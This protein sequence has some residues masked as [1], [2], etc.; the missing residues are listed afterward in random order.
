META[1]MEQP[2]KKAR[3]QAQ[4]AAFERCLAAREKAILAKHAN[5]P[6]V[7]TAAVSEPVPE[8]TQPPPVPEQDQA[9]PAAA[10]TPPAAPPAQ[11][12]EFEFFDADHLV[13]EIADTRREILAMKD[14]LAQLNSQHQELDDTFKAHRVKQAHSLNFV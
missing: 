12:D 13:N 11:E 2:I 9:P 14:A 4:V 10:P 1:Q 7:E 6:A 3:S 8:A 5:S